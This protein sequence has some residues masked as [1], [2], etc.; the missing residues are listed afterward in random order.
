[1]MSAPH[2][3]SAIGTLDGAGRRIL[4]L[5]GPSSGFFG[6]LADALRARG[7]TVERVLFHPGDALFWRRPGGVHW[8]G[9]AE[10]WP[11]WIHRRLVERGVTDL[12]IWGDRRPPHPPAVEA[13]Q[14]LGVRVHHMEL[15]LLRPGR[16]SL[17][18][19]G[20]GAHFPRSAEG[21]RRLA[22]LARQ[23]GGAAPP[24]PVGASFAAYAA[25]DALWNLGALCA[26]VSHPGYRRHQALHPLAGY[27]AWAAKLVLGPLR[28]A[29]ARQETRAAGL[30]A[31][32]EAPAFLFALQLAGDAQVR[33]RGPDA[34]LR[35]SLRRATASFAA[36]APPGAR[37]AVK[38]HPMDE[39]IIP[40]RRIARQAAGGAARRVH[41]LDGG[42]LAAMLPHAAGVVTVNSGAGLEALAAGR[43]VKALGRAVWDVP[44]MAHQGALE[45][46]WRAPQ[47]PDPALVADFLA[48]ID[49]AS[50]VPGGMDGRAAAVGA[51]SAA[52]RI[53]AP[54]RLGPGSAPV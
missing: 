30:T 22:H 36:H 51:A 45:D 53:L 52:E 25:S 39:R 47:R 6:L 19:D 18:P 4:L 49:W 34:D 17:E 40:W 42:A 23:E 29:R 7:A 3:F 46:F 9:G 21:V 5:Q 2:Q 48:A 12:V 44:G 16:L 24:G 14:A 50:H 15:G 20:P 31:G 38:L 1:M 28:R 37:L 43:P 27:A 26:A 33:A 10:A 54:P 11:G 41:V 8:R 35:D 13:A 32:A